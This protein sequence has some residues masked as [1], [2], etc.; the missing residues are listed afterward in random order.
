LVRLR[1]RR[2]KRHDE[3]RAEWDSVRYNSESFPPESDYPAAMA[4]YKDLDE[5]LSLVENLCTTEQIAS[6][7]RNHKGN[8]N[9]RISAENKED[10]VRR[11]LRAA[12]E[13]N[14][15]DVQEIFDLIRSSEENGNQHIF[16]WRPNNSKMADTLTLEHVASQLW[17]GNW[18]RTVSAFPSI[19]LKPDDYKYSDFRAVS[20][21]KP[22]DWILKVYGQKTIVRATG[23]T[24]PEAPGVFWREFVEESLRIVLAARWNYP[25]LLEIRVQRNESRRRIEDWHKQVW[26]MLEPAVVRSQFAEWPLKAPMKRIALEGEK[27]AKTYEFRDAGV[28]D[29]GGDVF[30]SFQTFSDQGNL[31]KSQQ[32]LEAINS[33]IKAGGALN[34]LAVKWLPDPNAEPT[35]ELRVLLGTKESNEMVVSG[36]CT[37]GDLDYVTD[38]LRRFSK[39]AS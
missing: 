36:R 6:L 3:Y 33:F 19:R 37:A 5:A 13:A 17:G 21:R 7:L 1:V 23:K 32:T 29:K 24:K 14:A 12:V 34:G 8:A 2:T 22:K 31:F 9:I 27:H 38:Q 20:K 39:T 28:V 30:A 25:D 10:L 35:E 4:I 15:L 16:Y 11:N 26:S 18:Q